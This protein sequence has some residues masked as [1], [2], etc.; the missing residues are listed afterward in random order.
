MV[1]LSR[2]A[3][4]RRARPSVRCCRQRLPQRSLSAIANTASAS[5]TGSRSLVVIETPLS[6]IRCRRARH[7]AWRGCVAISASTTK[8]VSS[9]IGSGRRSSGS[10]IAKTPRVA[11]RRPPEGAMAYRR[12]YMSG[13][14]RT[15]TRSPSVARFR[16]ARFSSG[17]LAV[18]GR[19]SSASRSGLRRS[20]LPLVCVVATDLM[21][22][23]EIVPACPDI[24]DLEPST[25]RACLALIARAACWPTCFVDM[26]LIWHTRGFG[27]GEAWH[28]PGM[29]DRI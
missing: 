17:V 22:S 29:R 19:F 7:T 1:S 4:R 8:L 18:A 9:A 14:T 23:A 16:A 21:I 25:M 12:P 15:L 5:S 11:G 3:A 27:E 20:R 26:R 28:G 6:S 2:R 10:S 13:V 24:L